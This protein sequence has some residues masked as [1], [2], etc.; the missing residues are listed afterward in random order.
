M[1]L[2]P[3]L[4]SIGSGVS[5]FYSGAAT[6]SVRFPVG[7]THLQRTPG[8]SGNQKKWTSSFWVKRT[9]LGTGYLW[10]GASYSGN[11]GI[12]A[13]YFDSDQLHT[14]YDGS[15]APY[16]AIGPDLYR[17]VNA[18]YHIVWAVDAANAVHRIW[19]N[20]VLRST[21]TN[22]Y[23]ENFAWGMNRANTLNKFGEAAWGNSAQFEG[24]LADFYH[25]DGQYLDYTSFAEFKNGVLIPK[26]TSGLTFGTNGFHLEFKQ[27]SVGSGA[28]DTIGADT[29]GEDNHLDSAIIAAD[30]CNMPDSPENNFATMNQ[31]YVTNSNTTLSDGNLKQTSAA[32][33]LLATSTIG[34]S[35]GKWYAELKMIDVTNFSFGIVAASGDSVANGNTANSGYVGK[36]ADGYG[37]W[38]NG[39]SAQTI[40]NNSNVNYGANPSADDI[41]ML[42]VDMDNGDVFMGKEGTWFNS[43]NPA[44]GTNPAF[45]NQAQLQDG[46]TWLIAGGFENCNGYWNFGQNSVFDDESAGGNADGNGIGDFAYAPPSGYLA[47]C[48]VNL[49][50]PTISPNSDTQATDYFNTVLYT[51][52]GQTA[53]QGSNAISGVGFQPDWVWLKK[54]DSAG[55]DVDHVA[56]DSTRGINAAVFP[57][58]TGAES[59]F[60]NQFKSFD[61]DGFTVALADDGSFGLN[62]NNSPFVAWNWKANGGTA[63]ATISESGNNPAA[64]VQANP[65]AGFS[66]ITYTGTGDAGTIA[67]GLGAVP[68]MMI[69]KNR[70]AADAWAVYHSENTAAP[71]TDYLV[72]NTTAATADAATYWADTAPTSSVFTVHDAHNVNAD[73]EK[74]VAYVFASISGYS[75]FGRYKGNANDN[76]A[77]VYLGFK[78]AW[79]MI[80]SSSSTGDF[81]SWVIYDNKRTPFNDN[82]GDTSNPLY[83]NNAAPEGERGN[84]TTDIS[85]NANAID[86]LS[87]GFKLRDNADEIN[88]AETYIYMAFADQPI[89]YANAE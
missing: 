16:G 62:R 7:E 12:A 9:K 44:N 70:D 59:S 17:D 13:I 79:I 52:N 39:A 82:T 2:L 8:T 18:W 51:G 33:W 47:L 25:L 67:H 77:Y 5:N 73:G 81:T 46:S 71:A 66:I 45:N 83:A 40:N 30:D 41:F 68:Q 37:W 24:Y 32:A 31:S 42:A 49:P 1:S 61:S 54:R 65:T 56:Y 55:A 72:L 22:N 21:N 84:G 57:S 78:P 14:Y 38:G 88:S 63:T 53:A 19:V 28:A 10:S 50:E 4:G 69:I 64:S 15:S 75:K 11:D 36:Y 35:S 6:Q 86:F 3:N 58:N 48:T 29:S 89:K 34:F 27:N 80:K 43:G 20:G 26:V 23:P 60:S 74:Y 76:G 87:N 85:G